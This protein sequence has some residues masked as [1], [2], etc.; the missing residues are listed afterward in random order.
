MAKIV[1]INSTKISAF[2]VHTMT[3]YLYHFCLSCHCLQLKRLIMRLYH[4]HNDAMQNIK[5]C[6]TSFYSKDR[7][8][9][10]ETHHVLWSNNTGSLANKYWENIIPYRKKSEEK[11]AISILLW[12]WKQYFQ[13]LNWHK[14]V[15]QIWTFFPWKLA[16]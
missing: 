13:H 4:P 12:A 9:F 3:R 8:Y 7:I 10:W 6:L 5:R 16:I 2:K 1:K 14:I 11:V 15:I